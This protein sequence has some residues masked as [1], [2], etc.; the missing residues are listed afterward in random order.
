MIVFNTFSL[1]RFCIFNNVFYKFVTFR[2]FLF[3]LFWTVPSASFLLLVLWNKFGKLERRTYGQLTCENCHIFAKKIIVYLVIWKI[4][5]Y[6][7]FLL[8]FLVIVSLFSYLFIN[9]FALP[10]SNCLRSISIMRLV[11]KWINIGWFDGY[12]NVI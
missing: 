10:Q 5:S 7:L 9:A 3:V 11:A 1:Q 6:F 12:I 8:I 4:F 2:T